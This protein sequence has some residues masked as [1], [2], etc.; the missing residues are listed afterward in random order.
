MSRKYL[1]EVWIPVRGFAEWDK[2]RAAIARGNADCLS[3]EMLPGNVKTQQ[4]VWE[5]GG[6]TYRVTRRIGTCD[7]RI[8]RMEEQWQ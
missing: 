6:N 4:S 7:P 5:I 3:C 2:V 1:I 8:E